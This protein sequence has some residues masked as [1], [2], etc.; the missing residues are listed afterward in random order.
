MY[1]VYASVHASVCVCGGGGANVINI[2]KTY[3]LL[4]N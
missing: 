3:S 1:I 4:L 2:R